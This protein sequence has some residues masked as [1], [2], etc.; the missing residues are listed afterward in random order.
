MENYL[1]GEV[2]ALFFSFLLCFSGKMWALRC[3]VKLTDQS[4]AASVSVTDTL[5]EGS[6][7]CGVS[8]ADK[9]MPQCQF[10]TLKIPESLIGT[11]FG[12][13]NAAQDN[14]IMGRWEARE[15]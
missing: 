5:E 14:C 13:V 3:D 8:R 1:Y 12:E 9:S 10:W 4:S 15:I 6:R 11:L 7:T 2:L